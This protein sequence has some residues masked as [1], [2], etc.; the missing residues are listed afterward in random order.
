MR[1]RCLA[2][3][4]RNTKYFHGIASA[5]RRVNSISSIQVGDQILESREDIELAIISFNNQLYTSEKW[6]RPRA[7][8]VDFIKLESQ[9]A[10]LIERPFSEEE[11]KVA[12]FGLGEDKVSYFW[13]L[14]NFMR[15]VL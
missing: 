13:F 14:K 9:S 8:G 6:D 10:P 15:M 3:G 11:I 4:D 5:R 7:D 12:V 1:V 2:D